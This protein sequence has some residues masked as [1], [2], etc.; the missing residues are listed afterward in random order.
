MRI[1]RFMFGNSD[2]E[3]TGVVQGAGGLV[4]SLERLLAAQR[5][6]RDGCSHGLFEP[7][8]G[9]IHVYPDWNIE[10]NGQPFLVDLRNCEVKVSR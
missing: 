9:C 2:R 8:K 7:I 1:V 6:A 10:D 4:S 3:I 5:L